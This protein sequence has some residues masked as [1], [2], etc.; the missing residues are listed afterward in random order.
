MLMKRDD[1]G[2]LRPPQRGLEEG[3]YDD[4]ATMLADG[5]ITRARAIKLA[6]ATL[7]AGTGM[8]ALFQSPAD[9]RKKKR[10]GRRR[11]RKARV[12]QQAPV[13]PTQFVP[14]PDTDLFTAPVVFEVTNPSDKPLTISDVEVV[15]GE[16]LA[17]ASLLNGESVTIAPNASE[18]VTVNLSTSDPLV[19]AGSLQFIA[20]NGLPV[21]VVDAND[22]VVGDGDIDLAFDVA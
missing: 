3:S 20:G 11:R 17:D 16:G 19:D 10:R 4:V 12:E 21:T 18:F 6:G 13:S 5:T 8:M 2:E 1:G 9:A 22:D 7:L 14:I 15:G